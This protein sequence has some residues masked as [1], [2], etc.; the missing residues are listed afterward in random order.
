MED[1][2]IGSIKMQDV[3]PKLSLT[4]G[5]V[6]NTGPLLDRHN[7]QVYRDLLGMDE[8]EIGLLEEE[9]FS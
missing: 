5:K 1:P 6:A 9:G 2:T 8:K 4:P 7:G 3:M